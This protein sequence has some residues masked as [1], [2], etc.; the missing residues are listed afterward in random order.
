MNNDLAANV[1]SKSFLYIKQI[2]RDETEGKLAR[3]GC[4]GGYQ[5]YDRSKQRRHGRVEGTGA[6]VTT[7]PTVRSGGRER[8]NSLDLQP[9]SVRAGAD[10]RFMPP[11]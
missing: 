7:A 10:N 11:E 4:S 5:S 6:A 3:I 9:S 1:A 8:R 2:L